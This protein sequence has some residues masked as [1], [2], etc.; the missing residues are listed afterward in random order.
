M[1]WVSYKPWDEMPN[2]TYSFQKE[3]EKTRSVFMG[4]IKCGYNGER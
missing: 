1:F 3:R 2:K 4:L